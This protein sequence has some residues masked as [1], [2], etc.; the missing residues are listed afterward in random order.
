[1]P[2]ALLQKDEVLDRLSSA[3]RESGY[4]G[5]TLA[6]LSE[7]TGLQRASLYHYFPGGKEEMAAAVLGRANAWMEERALTPLTDPGTPRERLYAMIEALDAFYAGG[8]DACLLGLLALSPARDLFQL[9]VQSAL[10]RWASAI[11]DVLIEAGLPRSEAKERG[12]DAVIQIQGALIVA[13]GLD[14]T[15]PFA[16]TLKQLPEKLLRPFEPGRAKAPRPSKRKP[17]P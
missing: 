13:R 14:S 10:T 16:R 15:A 2:A 1:M 11:A 12:E 8:R 9:A 3:F 17:R 7:A 5:A 4:E 6:R